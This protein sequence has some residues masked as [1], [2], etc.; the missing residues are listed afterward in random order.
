[1]VHSPTSHFDITRHVSLT[2][3]AVRTVFV[4]VQVA[5]REGERTRTVQFLPVVAVSARRFGSYSKHGLHASL[6][7]LDHAELIKSGWTYLG[8]RLLYEPVVASP[9]DGMRSGF[10]LLPGE[11]AAARTVAC[12]WPAAE[13]PVRLAPV[14]E[15]LASHAWDNFEPAVLST[16]LSL[17]L[18]G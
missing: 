17:A 6:P 10:D 18:G 1:M 14:V 16:A 15:D 2:A 11:N 4:L 5:E 12:S 3:P 7:A 13:D 8:D 9:A